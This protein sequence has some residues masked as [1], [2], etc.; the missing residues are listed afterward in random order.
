MNPDV[1][2]T[3]VFVAIAVLAALGGLVF[4]V[5]QSRRSDGSG[6]RAARRSKP[7]DGSNEEG[8]AAVH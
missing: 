8:S 4:V 6:G 7:S 3:I 2:I 1:F 5:P